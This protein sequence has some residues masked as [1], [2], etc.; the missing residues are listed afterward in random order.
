MVLIFLLFSAAAVA[1]A[2][3]GAFGMSLAEASELE[4]F[5]VAA[6]GA[7]ALSGSISGFNSKGDSGSDESRRMGSENRRSLVGTLYQQGGQ[8]ARMV[9]CGGKAENQLD[10]TT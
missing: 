2:D 7:L 3:G 6:K 8:P 5:S 1:N 9:W 4:E 10:Y